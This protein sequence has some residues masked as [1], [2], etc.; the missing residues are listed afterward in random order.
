TR[1]SYIFQEF[2][3]PSSENSSKDLNQG[4]TAHYLNGIP[5]KL[6]KQLEY[7]MNNDS[8]IDKL[9]ISE[10]L[11]FIEKIE[12]KSYDYSFSLEKDIVAEMNSKT[13]D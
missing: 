12:G 5:F 2:G 4:D 1:N 11:S 9:R 7:N 8:E 6:C 13:D 3:Q 10:I